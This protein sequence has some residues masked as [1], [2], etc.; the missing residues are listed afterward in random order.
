M[1]DLLSIAPLTE[2]VEVRGATVSVTGAGVKAI[3]QLL[4]R[5]PELRKMWGTGKWDVDQLVEMS[6]EVLNALVAAGVPAI[7]EANAANLALDEKVELLGAVIKVTMPRG[8]SPFMEALTKLMSG[9]GG[10]VSE[11]APA[12][13]SP[14]PS[15]R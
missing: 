6:D 10:A 1:A 14:K 12:T 15:K 4:F 7:D 3:A 11:K 13:K 2:T 8:P 9:V 5:F